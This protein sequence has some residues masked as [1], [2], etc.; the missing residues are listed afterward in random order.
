[1]DRTTEFD[2][3]VDFAMTHNLDEGLVRDHLRALWTAYC[4]HYNL[5]VD[6]TEYDKDLIR[7]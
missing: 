7:L 6:T 5:A 2:Y 3:M 1:M 4:L